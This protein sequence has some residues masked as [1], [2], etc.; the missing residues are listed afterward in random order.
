MFL[1]LSLPGFSHS[2]ANLSLRYFTYFCSYRLRLDT[3]LCQLCC[4]LQARA[5][6][7]GEERGAPGVAAAASVP[8]PGVRGGVR[9]PVRLHGRPAPHPVIRESALS[10]ERARLCREV[11]SFLSF[12]HHKLDVLSSG[13]IYS[14]GAFFGHVLLDITIHFTS[15]GDFRFPSEKG[16]VR[17]CKRLIQTPLLAVVNL[18][19]PPV[20][21]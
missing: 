14:L 18:P 3:W 5:P 13:F 1:A 4:L 2:F 21:R 12:L 17:E 20:T 9:A 15:S 16:L 11:C 8:A 7:G 6:G 10:A 19:E